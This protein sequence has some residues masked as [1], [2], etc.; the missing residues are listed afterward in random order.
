MAPRNRTAVCD[1]VCHQRRK[2]EPVV[3]FGQATLA[4]LLID[5]VITRGNQQIYGSALRRIVMKRSRQMRLI[6]TTTRALIT[7]L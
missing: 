1:M 5:G 3:G 7:M 2:R 4:A 6:P